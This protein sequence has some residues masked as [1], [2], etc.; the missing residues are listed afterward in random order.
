MGTN[1]KNA[2]LSYSNLSNANLSYAN[3]T[4]ANLMSSQMNN[5]RFDHAI[6]TTGQQCAPQSIGECIIR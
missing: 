3:L 6:W 2:D 4:G 5:A 1:L